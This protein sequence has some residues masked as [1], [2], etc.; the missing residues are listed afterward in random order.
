MSTKKKPAA[1]SAAAGTGHAWSHAELMEVQH[2]GPGIIGQAMHEAKEAYLRE[3]QGGILGP[4]M[5]GEGHHG[6]PKVDAPAA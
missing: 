4:A 2:L 6:A 3:S 5:R 1:A